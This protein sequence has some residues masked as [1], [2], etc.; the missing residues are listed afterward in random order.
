[1]EMVSDTIIIIQTIID[2]IINDGHYLISNSHEM[3]LENL[4][5]KTEI[6]ML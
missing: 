4:Q 6:A 2:H 5:Q 3:V 1:M